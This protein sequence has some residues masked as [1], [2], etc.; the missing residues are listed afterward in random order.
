M[1]RRGEDS[2]S[3]KIEVVVEAAA[4][5]RPEADEMEPAEID[6]G[7]LAQFTAAEIDEVST[8]DMA[9]IQA[10]LEAV[11]FAADR[12]V[13]FESLRSVFK[14]TTAKTAE[15]KKALFDLQASMSAPDRG[16][17]LEEISGGWHVRT[18]KEYTSLL[19]RAGKVKPFRLSGPALE[20]LSIV[21]YKQP[22]VKSEVDDIRG[23]ES[24][25]LMRALMDRGLVRFGGKSDLPGKPMWYE[26]TRKF[27]EIFG[28]RSIQELPTPADIDSLIPEGIGEPEAEVKKLGDLTEE[29]SLEASKTYSEGEEELGKITEQLSHISSSSE[30]FEIEKQRE[31]ER[32]DLERARDIRDA[33]AFGSEVD[34]KD[35]RW[36]EKYDRA[37]AEA[38]AIRPLAPDPAL[39]AEDLGVA[40]TNTEVISTNEVIST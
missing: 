14:G 6:L 21:A 9:Q 34:P 29:L 20:V 17:S 35:V 10:T 25:H 38:E 5:D 16:V 24:G 27:L 28:L 3:H 33:L 15:I 13:S 19:R 1:S 40:A 31:R 18:K 12:P 30:F 4:D 23:V 11:L 8:V 26:T 39:E 37:R 22:V 2:K 32:R 36:L 7:E